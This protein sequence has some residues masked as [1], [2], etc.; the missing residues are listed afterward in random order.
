MTPEQH[1]TTAD[2]MEAVDN[3]PSVRGQYWLKG[4]WHESAAGKSAEFS[5]KMP[6]RIKPTPKLRPW[7]REE[8]EGYVQSNSWVRSKLGSNLY[9]VTF[10]G[11]VEILHIMDGDGPGQNRQYML[12]NYT[13]PDG[14][15]LGETE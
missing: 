13:Q 1:R 12:D 4:E 5:M 3:D 11:D 2:A 14:T 6:Y 9:L 10:V 8:W 7:T 15:P